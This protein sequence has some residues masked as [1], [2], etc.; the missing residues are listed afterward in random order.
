MAAMGSLTQER[1][2]VYTPAM[3]QFAPVQAQAR[4]LATL[5]AASPAALVV[6]GSFVE[7]NLE[8]G[9]GQ[10]GRGGQSAQRAERGWGIS[11]RV[12]VG[13]VVENEVVGRV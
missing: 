12:R 9:E 6:T 5:E 11:V 4:I 8:I 1:E 13:V 2:L 10:K 3:V 7:D